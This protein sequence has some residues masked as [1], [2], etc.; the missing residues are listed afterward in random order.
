MRETESVKKKLNLSTGDRAAGVIA[1]LLVVAMA[2]LAV[3]RSMHI[4]LIRGEF[5]LFIPF[6]L[7]FLALGWGVSAI[8]RRIARPTLRTVVG[9]VLSLALV[10]LAMVAF[11]YLSFVATLTVPQAYNRVTSPSGARRLVV[12]RRLDDDE[13]RVQ[14]RRDARLEA[15]PESDPEIIADDWCY[16]FTAYPTAGGIF[17]RSDADVEGAITIAYASGGTLMVEWSDDER[18][19]HFFVEGPGVGEGGD[20]YVRF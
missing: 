9:V 13:E 10:F 17:Y 7:V 11:S 15:D 18:E 20:V 6:L 19:A 4:E 8:V 16:A 12:L 5:M 1:I 3:L 2:V 14:A